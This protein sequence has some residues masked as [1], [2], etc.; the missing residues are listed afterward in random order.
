[1][2]HFFV[3]HRWV[4][5]VLL[6][7]WFIHITSSLIFSSILIF[8]HSSFSV[9]PLAPAIFFPFFYRRLPFFLSVISFFSLSTT[10]QSYGF[11]LFNLFICLFYCFT[12]PNNQLIQLIRDIVLTIYCNIAFKKLW[13]DGSS[14]STCEISIP[15]NFSSS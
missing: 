12:K 5:L 2:P 6:F 14:P 8:P 1:M 3:V 7:N 13:C 10:S 4:L 15:S 9:W 11:C